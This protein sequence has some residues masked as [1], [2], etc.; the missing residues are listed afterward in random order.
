MRRSYIPIGMP[1]SSVNAQRE[2]D[3]DKNRQTQPV[4]SRSIPQ[5]PLSRSAQ[6]HRTNPTIGDDFFLDDL[7][8]NVAKLVVSTNDFSERIGTMDTMLSAV[9]DV[10]SYNTARYLSPLH[11]MTLAGLS[12]TNM[13][14]KIWGSVRK[15]VRNSIDAAADEFMPIA[16][17]YER[18]L[19]LSFERTDENIE[20]WCRENRVNGTQL[21]II[22]SLNALSTAPAESLRSTLASIV[23]KEISGNWATLV[24]EGAALVYL[25]SLS[26]YAAYIAHAVLQHYTRP[27]YA[28]LK[29]MKVAVGPYERMLRFRALLQCWPKAED[30]MHQVCSI[31]KGLAEFINGPFNAALKGERLL[32]E[33]VSLAVVSSAKHMFANQITAPPAYLGWLKDHVQDA[34]W[35]FDER[36]IDQVIKDI[37]GWNLAVEGMTVMPFS[38]EE[39]V[40]Y[41]KRRFPFVT[42]ISEGKVPR[43]INETVLNIIAAQFVLNAISHPHERRGQEILLQQTPHG[44][45]VRDNGSG[46]AY[47]RLQDIRSSIR[48][49]SRLETDHE[50]GTG[51]GILDSVTL[52]THL[53]ASRAVLTLASKEGEGTVASVNWLNESGHMLFEPLPP[54]WNKIHFSSALLAS[55][56]RPATPV[57]LKP[58]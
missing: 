47:E 38:D 25:T 42:V 45:N 32:M 54:G 29:G 8:I 48:D 52:M 3:V 1:S 10:D 2:R 9:G 22:E 14:M 16:E 28:I 39:P 51:R 58:F 26:T 49:G 41:I 33:T 12:R 35:E 4:P 6:T 7:S 44:L 11:T 5:Q 19:R 17:R 40:V 36:R 21:R 34:M 24:I 50:G 18:N 57:S 56:P 23:R 20:S 53:T 46:I 43:T 13:A 30:D 27:L 31:F 15:A 55:V 37:E